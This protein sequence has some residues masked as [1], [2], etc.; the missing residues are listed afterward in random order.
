MAKYDSY[1]ERVIQHLADCWMDPRVGIVASGIFDP[2]HPPMITT[3]ERAGE[4]IWLHAE[5]NALLQFESKYGEPGPDTI[6][7]VTLSPCIKPMSKSRAGPSCTELLVERGLT[8]VHAGIIDPVHVSDGIQEYKKHGIH[9]TIPEDKYCKTI[10]QR[11]LSIFQFYG[12]R[13]N[14]DLL[15]I[16]EEI[17][18]CIFD[19]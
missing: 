6:V 14:Y 15:T 8:K 19:Q 4:G 13:V 5:R 9:L 18:Y 2:G 10:C 12:N 7:V 16:K 1:L 11:L 17:G 3:S